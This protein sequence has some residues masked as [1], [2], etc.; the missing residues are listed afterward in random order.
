[1]Q[2]EGFSPGEPEAEAVRV[3]AVL[4]TLPAAR[5][6]DLKARELLKPCESLREHLCKKKMLS[7]G[8]CPNEGGGR[9]LP[10]LKNTLYIFIFDG[11]KR[12][13]SCPK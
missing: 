1:M 12:H 2:I 5:E 7:F 9:T 3:A 6:Q 11:R 8:H 4:V 10:E 13:T